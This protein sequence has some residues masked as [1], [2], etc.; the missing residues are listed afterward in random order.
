MSSDTCRS[1]ERPGEV[2]GCSPRWPDAESLRLQI[3][4]ESS[5]R[6]DGDAAFVQQLHGELDRAH[7]LPFF[8]HFDQTNIP[9]FGHNRIPADAPQSVTQGIA[10]ESD[11]RPPSCRSHRIAM[12]HGH[13]RGD[14]NRSENPVVVVTFDRRQSSHHFTIAAAEADTPA[15]H[16]VAFAHR[17]QFH[18]D[19]NRAR[20]S[21]GSSEPY[22]RRSRRPHKQSR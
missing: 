7:A 13:D 11:I 8:R 9:A 2:A 21:P 16:A 18:S 6:T 4:T 14:L 1:G 10:A 17:S 19:I 12:S 22:S 15:G 5:T 20:A 3:A